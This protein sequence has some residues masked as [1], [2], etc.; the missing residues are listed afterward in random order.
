LPYNSD[1]C[2]T[3]VCKSTGNQ[4]VGKKNAKEKII[5]NEETSDYNHWGQSWKRLYSK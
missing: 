1:V 5:Q 2:E 3:L 4:E